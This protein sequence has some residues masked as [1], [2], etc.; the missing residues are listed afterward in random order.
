MR[1]ADKFVVVTGAGSGIGQHI[2]V[3]LA[4]EGASLCLIGR[5]ESKLLE[6][7]KLILE[8]T[9]SESNVSI[10]VAD[11]ASSENV[12]KVFSKLE[13]DGKLPCGLVNA[14]GINPSRNSITNTTPE[15]WQK[16]LDT[17]LTGTFNCMREAMR[18][19]EK[20][21]NGS[22]VN[23]ASIAGL[24]ALQERAAYMTSKW[25]LVGLTKSAALDY[26]NVGVRVNCVC[27]GYVETPLVSQY[28]KN[29]PADQYQK[30]INSHPMQRLGT[31][32]DITPL[33]LLLLSAESS[34]ITGA[35]IPV[36]GGYST[37]KTL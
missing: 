4:N 31:P 1:F 18:I 33:V 27:P 29:L 23:I 12:T 16:T 26:A 32:Q 9:K 8:N 15:D 6:T 25:G 7:K 34:W 36:D 10:S 30:L 2:A 14:A 11:V 35:I 37:G 24:T 3:S 21:T 28:L 22:I 5:T 13:A 20:R 17:N 19:M